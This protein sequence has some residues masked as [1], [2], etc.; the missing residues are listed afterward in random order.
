MKYIALILLVISD[1]ALTAS[2]EQS[3]LCV[4]DK[5]AG[6]V[7]NEGQWFSAKLGISEEDKFVIRPLKVGDDFYGVNGNTHGIFNLGVKFDGPP[8][9]VQEYSGYLIC[10]QG[11]NEEIKFSE[12]T[13]RFVETSTLGYWAKSFKNDGQVSV[14]VGSCTKI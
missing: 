7:L 12:E 4:R 14:I 13:L 11:I 8:C 3:F 6:I 10:R 2:F 9:K 1:F 5:A